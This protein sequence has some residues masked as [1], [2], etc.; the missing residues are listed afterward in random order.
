VVGMADVISGVDVNPDLVTDRVRAFFH[1]SSA[2]AGFAWNDARGCRTPKPGSL[3]RPNRALR[4][5]RA[6]AEL[7]EMA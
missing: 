7:V 5:G 6:I 2:H 3:K 4:R 1:R